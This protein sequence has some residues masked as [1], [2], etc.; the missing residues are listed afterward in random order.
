MF[1]AVPKP[2]YFGVLTQS[3]KYDIWEAIEENTN[4]NREYRSSGGQMKLLSRPT[5]QHISDNSKPGMNGKTQMTK[6]SA[7]H[8]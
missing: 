7:L 4:G 5:L 1:M 3:P 8:A 6:T 2:K